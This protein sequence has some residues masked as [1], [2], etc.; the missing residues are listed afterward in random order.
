VDPGETTKSKATAS[1]A[2]GTGG[3]TG[4]QQEVLNLIVQGR[5]N[6]EIARILK[7]GEGTVKVHVAALFGKLGINRRAAVAVAGARFVLEAKRS[8]SSS[9]LGGEQGS[10]AQIALLPRSANPSRFPG[11]GYT[12]RF[13]ARMRPSDR[14][15]S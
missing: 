10:S 9:R 12:S 6:K 8:D 1:S 14:T 7:L 4:R 5:S 3:L 13:W 11:L 2:P 15:R